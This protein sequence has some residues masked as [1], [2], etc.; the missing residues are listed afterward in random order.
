MMIAME[1]NIVLEDV[2]NMLGSK[3]L[4]MLGSGW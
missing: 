3:W 1:T 2:V 4:I